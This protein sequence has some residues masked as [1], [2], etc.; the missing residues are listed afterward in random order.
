MATAFS[1]LYRQIRTLVGDNDVRKT[2][3]SD[4]VLDSHIRNV[5]LTYTPDG[6]VEDSDDEGNFSD[7]LSVAQKGI[8][9]FEVAIFIL[10]QTPADFTFRDP[11]VHYRKK[12]NQQQWIADL[13]SKVL[14]LQEVLSG[15][16]ATAKAEGILAAIQDGPTKIQDELG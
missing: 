16:S 9:I 4:R 2:V 12:M 8:V 10:T 14:A 3:Y 13:K 5:I 7:T 11:V 1:D 6:I 15:T